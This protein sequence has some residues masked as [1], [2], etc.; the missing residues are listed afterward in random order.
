MQMPSYTETIEEPVTAKKLH[1]VLEDALVA[2]A[3]P[4]S[5]IALSKNRRG[6][7][8]ISITWTRLESPVEWEEPDAPA[9]D[10]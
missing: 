10:S 4:E 5:V 6:A 1:D 8:R 2:G 3:P 7:L 9:D